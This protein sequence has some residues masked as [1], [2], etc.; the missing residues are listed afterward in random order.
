MFLKSKQMIVL[1][2]FLGLVIWGCDSQEYTS[3]KLYIQNQDWD[4]AEEFLLKALEV[5]PDNPEIPVQVAYHVY[6][7]KKEWTKMNAMFDRALELGA[8]KKILQ[9]RPTR[10]YVEKFRSMFWADSYNEGVKIF[11]HYNVSEDTTDLRKAAESFEITKT[12]NQNEGQAYIILATC[13][14]KLNENDRALENGLKAAELLPEDFQANLALGQ[15][16]ARQNR[17]EEALKY[18]SKAVEIDPS[19]SFAIR[20]LATTYYDLG[21]IEESITTF[22]KAIAREED[23]QI[24]ADLY[25]NLGVL[26]MR[27]ERFQEAEDSFMSALDLNP[28]DVEA[29]LGMAQTFENAEKWSRAEKFYRELIT[30]QPDNPE[31]YRGMARVLVKKGNPDKATR[32][33][34]RA[35]KLGG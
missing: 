2:T 16:L 7:R 13:Y 15:I 28:E 5:E 23:K 9:G 27:L 19:N 21:Q 14:S 10:E 11:N 3:A 1:F 8:D 12:I 31:H 6:G 32:Y 22:E 30:L 17:N 20:M 26:N 4:R 18:L 35:K 34:E 29:L 24:K 25:F 33:L